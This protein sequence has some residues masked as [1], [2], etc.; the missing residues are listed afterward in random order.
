M[1]KRLKVGVIGLGVGRGHAK[2][3]HEMEGAELV[4]LADQDLAWAEQTAAAMENPRVYPTPEAL[5]ADSDVEAVS[6]CLPTRFHC[7]ATLAALEAGKHVLVEKPMA[8]NLAEAERMR[9]AARASGKTLA[10]SHNQRFTPQARFLERFIREGGL[11]QVY[12]CRTLWRR[13]MGSLPAPQ[14]ERPTGAYDRNWFN[15]WSRGGGV[16]RDLGTHMIDRALYVLGFPRFLSASGGSY[17]LVGEA[18]RGAR[19]DA[20]DFTAGLVQLEN[21][22]LAVE[23][24]FGMHTDRERV[25]TEIY[26]TRGGVEWESGVRL[27]TQV[28]TAYG[29]S[30]LARFEEAVE[31]SQQNFVEAVLAGRPPLVTADQGVE[32]MRV[33]DAIYRSAGREP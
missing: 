14:Q 1:S 27:F 5:L 13:P 25:A 8:S 10:V 30:E 15:E 2:A 16:L 31:S 21:M 12:F 3:Y 18:A 28:G 6:I 22:T 29:Q 19:F 9:E 33:I 23:V 11:G 20:D 7:E 4:A 32:V 24:S 17:G 26:G